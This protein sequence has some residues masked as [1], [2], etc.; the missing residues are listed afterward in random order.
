MC[1]LSH[2]NSSNSFLL[3]LFFSLS[4]KVQVKSSDIQVGDMI[5]VEKVNLSHV[6]RC[7][8]KDFK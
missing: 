6:C 7:A 4:G 1:R 2:F 5:I 8:C 3:F